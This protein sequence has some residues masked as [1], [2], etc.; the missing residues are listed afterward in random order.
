MFSPEIMQ[1]SSLY[2]TSNQTEISVSCPKSS[3][4]FLVILTMLSMLIYKKFR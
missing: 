1:M 3:I 2:P 4:I